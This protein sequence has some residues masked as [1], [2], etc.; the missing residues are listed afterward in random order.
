MSRSVLSR[1]GAVQAYGRA[2]RW[3]R[4]ALRGGY[5]PRALWETWGGSY[6]TEPGRKAT[7]PEHQLLGEVLDATAPETLVEVGCGF[8]RNL[9]FVL[10]HQRGPG[11]EQLGVA[12]RTE[13]KQRRPRVAVGIDLAVSMLREAQT[14]APGACLAAGDIR[15]LPLATGSADL[16]LTHGVL[17]HVPPSDLQT[18]LREVA[19][20]ASCSF[21]VEEV[22]PVRRPGAS[23]KINPYTFAHDYREAVA[24]TG[25]EITSW[26]V[27]GPLVRMTLRHRGG[28]S[29]SPAVGAPLP[30][31]HTEAD[32]PRP[33]DAHDLVL[34]QVPRGSRV[35]ELGCA[36]GYL[37]RWMGEAGATVVGIEIDADSAKLAEQWCE[38][39]IVGSLEGAEV[40]EEAGSGYD[41]VLAA[42]VI[43]HLR[44]P[45]EALRRCRQALAPGGRIIVNLP[46]VAHW[47]ERLLHLRGRFDYEDYGIRDRTHLKFFT[48]HTALD[49]FRRGGLEVL[50]FAAARGP[51]LMP[52]VVLGKLWPGGRAWLE[53]SFPNLFAHEMVFTL[54]P[55]R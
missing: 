49:L 5:R 29:A 41:V 17:M 6:S 48:Y 7:G 33:G 8:G 15:A 9:R 11:G 34:G 18:A 3:L 4:F 35:L 38:R 22:R 21:H 31:Y 53:G 24:R 45:L 20:V 50:G 13:G 1:A 43:E 39:V 46:N 26:S 54:V 52:V 14:Y 55:A 37:S 25:S 51:V 27:E 30:K 23:R 2:R 16:L 36:T 42:A 19:R 12:E 10:G 28:G 47:Q 44:D 32:A 40:W